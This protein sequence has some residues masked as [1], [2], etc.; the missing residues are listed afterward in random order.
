MPTGYSY[1]IEEGCTFREFVLGCSRAF[2]ALISMRDSANDAEI[3]D[4]FKPSKYHQE[5]LEEAVAKL[6]ALP[7]M[8]AEEVDA[9]RKARFNK[10][11]ADR[12][13]YK[14]EVEKHQ[15]Q[16]NFMLEKVHA[17][18]PPT[19]GHRDLKKFMIEQIKISIPE[20]Q[21]GEPP[22]LATAKEWMDEE[23]VSANRDIEYHRKHYAEEVERCKGR[24]EWVRALKESLVG[25]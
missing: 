17:W 18:T 22:V 3:P 5:G 13:R 10:V 16:Y 12:E 15:K 2:G 6:K 8:S 14:K 23:V 25:K 1:P 7:L 24:T 4:E 19:E 9:A 20:Y 11:V 21:T